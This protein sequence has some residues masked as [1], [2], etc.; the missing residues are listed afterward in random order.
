M[1]KISVYRDS[2]IVDISEI[3]RFENKIG[4]E[5]PSEYK[6]LISKHNAL[7]PSSE[8]FDF[9][10]NGE[11]DSRDVSFFGYGESVNEYEDIEEFQQEDSYCYE[12][13]VVIGGTANGDYICFD[14]RGNPNS[15]NPPVIVMLHDST[16]E[17]NKMLIC[18]VAD[19]FELFIE[20]LYAD[21]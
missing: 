9:N 10:C 15:N 16:D 17:N 5:F 7:R 18:P 3:E 6:Y 19:N 11:L 2:G 13:I 14:Y 4:Y 8:C 21:S 20:S 1:K 12:H